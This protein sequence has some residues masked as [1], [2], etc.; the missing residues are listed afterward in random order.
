VV[1]AKPCLNHTASVLA[2][3]ARYTHRIAL[4]EQRLV[5]IDGERV[6]LRY[7]DYRDERAHKTVWL[8]GSELVRRFLLH[9]LPKGFMRIRHYGLLANR[10]RAQCLAMARHAIAVA[11][12]RACRAAIVVPVHTSPAHCPRCRQPLLHTVHR[13]AR[14]RLEGG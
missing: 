7:R 11:R 4:S 2:Y 6:G 13:P 14:H 3:L 1:Y 9:V 10:C 12:P 5:G 8:E